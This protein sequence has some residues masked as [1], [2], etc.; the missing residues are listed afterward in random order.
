MRWSHEV[1]SRPT[2]FGFMVPNQASNKQKCSLKWA[3]GKGCVLIMQDA[4]SSSKQCSWCWSEFSK[5]QVKGATR[6]VCARDPYDP[7]CCWMY[8][9]DEPWDCKEWVLREWV[10]TGEDCYG[11]HLPRDRR[12]KWTDLA[13]TA[14]QN[15]ISFQQEVALY[16]ATKITQPIL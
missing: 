1:P 8:L 14:H 4:P 7:Q 11:K 3:G 12:L 15:L 10:W 6:M 16:S 2:L 9:E 5:G 13:N